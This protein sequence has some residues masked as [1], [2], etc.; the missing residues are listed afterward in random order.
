MGS[1]DGLLAFSFISFTAIIAK[2]RHRHIAL[3]IKTIILRSSH[4]IDHKLL[5]GIRPWCVA[6]PTWPE[7]GFRPERLAYDHYKPPTSLW[8]GGRSPILYKLYLFLAYYDVFEFSCDIF[9]QLMQL[10]A[11]RIACVYTFT[12][13]RA[14]Q[15]INRLADVLGFLLVDVGWGTWS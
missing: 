3:H 13:H 4:H 11:R 1:T 2:C 12:W 9:N 8:Q 6:S 7:E 14:L 10:Q 5:C 15:I